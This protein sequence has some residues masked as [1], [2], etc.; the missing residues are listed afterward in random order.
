MAETLIFVVYWL[1]SHLSE[2]FIFIFQA[3][4]C[5]ARPST[6]DRRLQENIDY[7]C[8]MV[9]CSAVKE[10]GSC[11]NPKTVMNHASFAMNL[12][13]QITGKKS[14]SCDFSGTALI[15]TKNPSK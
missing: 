1:S 4:W 5:I 6:E 10:E 9:D 15:I 12:Y 8:N 11:F 3:T 13:Y 2:L 7:A 14:S